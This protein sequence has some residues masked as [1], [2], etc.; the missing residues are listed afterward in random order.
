[1]AVISRYQTGVERFARLNPRRHEGGSWGGGLNEGGN[2][3]MPLVGELLLNHAVRGQLDRGETAAVVVVG[4]LGGLYV[5]FEFVL[6]EAERAQHRGVRCGV[7][8]LVGDPR[9]VREA[10]EPLRVVPPGALAEDIGVGLGRAFGE[11]GESEDVDEVFTGE[12][13]G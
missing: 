4:L 8:Q 1:M 5:A 7:S 3:P 6:G 10:G 2:E 12:A 13:V 11:H 9:T